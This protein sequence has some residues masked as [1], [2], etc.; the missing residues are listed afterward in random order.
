M[1]IFAI[2]GMP[3]QNAAKL[4]SAVAT[5]FADNHLQLTDRVW[6]VAHAG[7][8]KEL[9]DKLG[10][11]DGSNGSAVILEAASYFGRASNTIWSWIKTKWEATDG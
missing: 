4:P 5:K 3:S 10:V 6:L 11:T 1:A 2:I 7:T 8:A 9:S